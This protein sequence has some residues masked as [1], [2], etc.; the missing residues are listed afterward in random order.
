MNYTVTLADIVPAER[1]DGQ[2][3]TL[4]DIEENATPSA[5]GA[6]VL[7]TVSLASQPGGLDTD[8]SKPAT[9]R[10]TTNLATLAAGWYRVVLRTPA[11]QRDETGWMPNIVYRP[12]VADVGAL[13]HDRTRDGDMHELGTFTD[14]T[15]P[16][17]EQVERIIDTA[18]GLIAPRLPATLQA[19]LTGPARHAV[20]LQAAILIEG[21]YFSRDVA[22]GNSPVEVYQDALTAALTG[23]ITAEETNQPAP[24]QT[25]IGSIPLRSVGAGTYDIYASELLP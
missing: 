22:D 2:P 24:G 20:A 17:A 8:P 1:D 6:T 12:S 19:H 11:G 13:L 7:E 21:S 15:R 25:G 5:T 16:T 18:I 3:W 9:R 14:E 10:F 4:A 23:L